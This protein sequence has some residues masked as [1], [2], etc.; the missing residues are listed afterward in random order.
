M[1]KLAV[2]AQNSTPLALDLST[3]ADPFIQGEYLA[4]GTVFTRSVADMPLAN[5]SA[6]IAAYARTMPGQHNKLYQST[7]IN[8]EDFNIPIYI[9]D[10]S[11][12]QQ[13]Y[14]TITST[15]ARITTFSD[16]VGNTLGKIP[17]PEYARP[18]DIGDRAMAVYDKAT[19]MMREYFYVIQTGDNSWSANA[20]GYFQAAPGIDNLDTLNFWMQ[21]SRGGSAVVQMLNPLSQVGISEALAGQINHALSVT[22]PDARAGVISFPAKDSDGRDTNPNAPAQGQW[23]RIDPAIDLDS[24]GLNPFTLLLA[25]TIQQYGGYGADRNAFNFA[26]NAEAPNNY[27][28]QGKENPW[29]AGGEIAQKYGT[30]NINDFPWHL[31]QWAPTGWNDTGTDA[32]VYTNTDIRVD[33]NGSLH[34]L[35]AQGG[36]IVLPEGVREINVSIPTLTHN[37]LQQTDHVTLNASWADSSNVLASGSNRADVVQTTLP[38]ASPIQ[39]SPGDDVLISPNINPVHAETVAKLSG[40]ALLDY[41]V[42][43]GEDML[44]NVPSSLSHTLNGGDG[45][46]TLVGGYGIDFMY[47]GNGKDQFVMIM[48]GQNSFPYQQ[49]D[50]IRDF[51]PA[52][53]T[54][55]LTRA[56]GWNLLFNQVV[57]D[58]NVQRLQ[59]K[60]WQGSESYINAIEIR[61]YN[62][63]PLSQEEVLAATHI[64]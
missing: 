23:F 31:T 61:S 39:G 27:L 50:K 56:P 54:I 49:N 37:Q 30:L 2:V 29:R 35:P 22:L 55:V 62:G 41:V 32:G 5:N 53:D 58:E 15:D 60:V 8:T 25:K 10:S 51:N 7:S 20:A 45:N 9:V 13:H 63:Q 21:H 42:A 57:F 16:L 38:I 14:T 3:G 44:A 18:D 36:E 33:I 40:K 47:G 12:P 24:L 19:G 11:N 52:E 46:D 17:F 34:T 26:F 43:H 1:L 6:E 59:Y 48:D 28:A 64:L 4:N